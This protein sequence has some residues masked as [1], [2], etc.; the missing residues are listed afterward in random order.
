M[1]LGKINLLYLSIVAWVL[2]FYFLATGVH[3]WK[4]WLTI[5]V[6]FV[7]RL[8]QQLVMLIMASGMKKLARQLL[9]SG[10]G[11]TTRGMD[12]S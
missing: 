1:K 3:D 11:P 4:L 12:G 9:A 6:I 5:S 7:D 10:I 8:F 2:T